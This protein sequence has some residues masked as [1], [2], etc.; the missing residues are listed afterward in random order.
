LLFLDSNQFTGHPT[1]DVSIRQVEE[2][3]KRI[4]LGSMKNWLGYGVIDRLVTLSC[5]FADMI[6]RYSE[7]ISMN[8][9][10]LLRA[11]EERAKEQEPLPSLGDYS[12]DFCC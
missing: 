9:L 4:S 8:F 7:D 10:R 11:F 1:S 3:G 5:F 2:T 6:A 12:K